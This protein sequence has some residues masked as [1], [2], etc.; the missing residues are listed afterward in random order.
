M[1]TMRS[2]DDRA[3]RILAQVAALG[4]L[5]LAAVAMALLALQA[6]DVNIEL[7]ATPRITD[8]PIPIHGGL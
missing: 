6:P 8:Y 4:L 5:I 2:S 3:G 1:R 7:P